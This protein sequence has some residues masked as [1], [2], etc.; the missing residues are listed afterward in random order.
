M[1]DHRPHQLGIANGAAPC[2]EIVN[3]FGAAVGQE[4]P[5]DVQD[6]RD[7]AQVRHLVFIPDL[8]VHR[9][10]AGALLG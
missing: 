9:L 7:A 10:P 2:E 4:Q 5:I 1:I 3:E 8:V 6:R